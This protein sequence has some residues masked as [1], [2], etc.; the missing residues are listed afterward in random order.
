MPLLWVLRD[1]LKLTGTKYSC[2]VGECGCCTVHIDGKAERSC[3][4]TA[5]EAQ[6]K[7]ITTIE[8]LPKDPSGKK[9][10]D[11][12]AGPSVRLLP[13]RTDDAGLGPYLRVQE[14]RP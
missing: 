4:T 5:G 3:V 13:A 2:G 6:G 7:K 9:G 10:V 8:G 12:G 1:H 14:A 11:T